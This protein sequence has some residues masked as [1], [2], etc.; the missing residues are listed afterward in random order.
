MYFGCSSFSL[1]DEDRQTIRCE[2]LEANEAGTHVTVYGVT[3]GVLF[4]AVKECVGVP[5]GGSFF[6]ELLSEYTKPQSGWS[7][8]HIFR[9]DVPP[10]DVAMLVPAGSRGN[11]CP[12][13]H[14]KAHKMGADTAEVLGCV[15]V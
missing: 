5:S 8:R 3:F 10:R 15:E 12:R 6:D 2:R 13:L 9:A 1:P 4:S 14:A 7:K 11:N